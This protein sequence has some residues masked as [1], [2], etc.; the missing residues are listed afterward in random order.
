MVSSNPS[1]TPIDMESKLGPDGDPVLDPKVSEPCKW[2]VAS[3]KRIFWYVRGTLDF[4]LHLFACSTGL[5]IAYSDADWR[6]CPSTRRSTSGYCVFL[7]DNLLFWFS[8]RQQTIS[9]SSAE[10]EYQGV[11]NVV[12]E[13]AWIH[14]L[15]REL[16]FPFIIDI[17]FVRGMV[18]KGH[19]RVLHVSSRYQYAGIF[20]KGLPLALFEEFRTSLSV[21]SSPAQTT[22]EF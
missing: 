6:G 10:A 12:A 15:L 8:K 7:G 19:V 21:C 5:L 20:T 3:L 11:T 2:F 9:G 4:V 17:H 22:G 13:T 14:N 18:T 1:R 16:H